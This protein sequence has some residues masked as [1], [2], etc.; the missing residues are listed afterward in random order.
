MPQTYRELA[1]H[2]FHGML[3]TFTGP[4]LVVNG[5]NDKLNRKGEADLLKAAQ[6]GQLQ[7]VEQAHPLCNLEQPEAFTHLVRAF[8]QRLSV[9]IE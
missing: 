4:T 5:E 8:A 6:D 9:A 7:I 2:D 3:H 1:S